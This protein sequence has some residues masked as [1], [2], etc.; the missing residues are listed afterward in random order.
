MDS[1]LLIK[2]AHRRVHLSYDCLKQTAAKR[3]LW[4]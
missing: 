3:D 2:R 1:E 4:L